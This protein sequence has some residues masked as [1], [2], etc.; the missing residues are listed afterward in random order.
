M[1]N[2]KKFSFVVFFATITLSLLTIPSVS[3]QTCPDNAPALNPGPLEESW[4]IE[5]WMPRHEA[6][7]SEEGR[8]SA[9]LLLLGDSITHGWESTGKPVWDQYFGEISTFNLGFSGDRTENVLWRIENGAL[10]EISPELTVLMIGT[11]NTGH[12]QDLPECTARG[13]EMIVDQ[14]L[15][16]FHES[17]I[18]LLAI[19]P[20]GHEPDHELRQL[21]NEINEQI[22]QFNTKPGVHFL[23]I[24][25][26][27]LTEDGVLTEEIM[28]DMLHPNDNG[29]E[30]WAEEIKPVINDLLNK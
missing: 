28:P 18:L 24:N 22:A 3:A 4:A 23:D 26:I 13:I 5:W 10:E 8:K 9:K 16:E 21:N 2:R 30:L 17:Q 1:L 29:Y 11:N 25:H 6:K 14:L 7:R 27:F 20:R 19:F 12:R 15:S